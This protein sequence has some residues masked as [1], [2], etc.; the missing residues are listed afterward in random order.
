MWGEEGEELGI[1]KTN[2]EWCGHWCENGWSKEIIVIDVQ[3]T[4][5][6]ETNDVAGV[7]KDGEK[8]TRIDHGKGGTRWWRLVPNIGWIWVGPKS[9]D[10]VWDGCRWV[11][12]GG[13]F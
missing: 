6:D 3:I 5:I 7:A 11:V 8:G 1:G 13:G 2:G 12:V 4:H 10:I 9:M